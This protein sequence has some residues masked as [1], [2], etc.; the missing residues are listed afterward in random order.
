MIAASRRGLP[1]F[2]RALAGVAFLVLAP[3]RARSG[4][5][6]WS[7]F[8][9]VGQEEDDESLLDH[10]LTRPPWSWRD[11]WERSNRALRSSQGCFT[12]GQWFVDTDL[13]LRTPMGRHARFGIDVRDD[14]SDRVA[15]TYFDLSAR[16]LTAIGTPGV[17]FRPFYDK[18]R[19]DLALFYE[20]GAETASFARVTFAFEDAFNNLWAFRQTRVGNTSEPYEVHPFEPSVAARLLGRHGRLE[21]EGAWLTPS[22]KRLAPDP[23]S[24]AIARETSWGSY[25]RG[26]VE[27]RLGRLT[28]KAAGENRQARST[29]TAADSGG[30][31]GADMRRQWAVEA[32]FA[33][34]LG[35]RLE[36]ELTYVYQRRDQSSSPPYPIQRL[37]ANDVLLQAEGRWT[38]A[39]SWVGRV[40]AMYD[41]ITVPRSIGVR[42]YGSRRESRAY[43]GLQARFGQVSLSLVEGIELDPEPYEVWWVHDKAFLHVQATF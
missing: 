15:L 23:A 11:E 33:I 24:G 8:T 13:R 28:C 14:Q 20:A 27:L 38:I 25:G 43:L 41:G 29:R 26:A 10:L 35:E 7:T 4:T 37:E 18:S 40:G 30:A 2:L 17:S 19:Q 22:R 6:D 16:F 9:A 39:G 5:E 32:G 3:G 36:G 42:S 12:S 21:L 34:A 31:P 1:R